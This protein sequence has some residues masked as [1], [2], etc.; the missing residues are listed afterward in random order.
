MVGLIDIIRPTKSPR[1]QHRRTPSAR[2]QG[3]YRH[4][5][6]QAPGDIERKVGGP[7]GDAVSVKARGLAKPVEVEKADRRAGRSLRQ[8]L[9]RGLE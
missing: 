2:H 9:S 3:L 8:F 6:R 5:T 4:Q 7:A 1:G